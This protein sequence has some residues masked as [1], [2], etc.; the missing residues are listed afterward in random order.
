MGRETGQI[1]PERAAEV[2]QR[3]PEAGAPGAAGLARGEVLADRYVVEGQVGSG[4]R[5]TVYRAFDRGAG[6]WVAIKLLNPGAAAGE[7]ELFRELRV[8]RAIQHPHV[9]RIFDVIRDGARTFLTMEF[10]SRGTLADS[11]KQ[12]DGEAPDRLRDVGGVIAGLAAIHEAG[13][14]HRDLKP[15]NVLRMQDGRLVLSDFGLA[16]RI[17][18]TQVTAEHA[19]TPGY[20]A[21]ELLSGTGKPTAASDL[22]SLGVVL[23]AIAAGDAKLERATRAVVRSCLDA[24]PDRRPRD[25]SALLRRWMLAS[26]SVGRRWMRP[27]AG[28]V[29][30]LAL[31]LGLVAVRW[32]GDRAGR[33]PVCSTACCLAPTPPPT[34]GTRRLLLDV[35][36]QG[37]AA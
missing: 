1:G 23:R 11:L 27:L 33:G 28:A 26:R 34:G 7:E 13:L 25:A 24:D 8:A 2:T 15:E 30:G 35:S 19:G 4:G 22:W 16:R 6:A 9:C 37:L 17:D 12:G 3:L 31:V 10:A 32:R 36:G 29:L 21:P 5:G 20:I 14:L 18:Q